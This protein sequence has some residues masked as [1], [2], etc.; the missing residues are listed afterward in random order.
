MSF[1]K[2]IAKVT[3]AEDALEAHERRVAANLRQL[4]ASWRA[5]WTPGRIVIVGAVSGFF[6]GRAEP[7]KAVAKSGNA[8]QLITMLSGLFAGGSAQAAADDAEHAAEAAEDL[9]VKVAPE[10]GPESAE[11][12]ARVAA[13]E[14]RARAA[15][16]SFE[17]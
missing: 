8:M 13:T 1:D 12:A 17:P 6:F 10:P 3:Q 7:L 2:L 11:Y 5:G 16:E 4:K 15:A 14:Q 9:A